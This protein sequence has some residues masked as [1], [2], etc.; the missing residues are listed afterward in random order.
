MSETIIALITFLFFSI[1]SIIY[2]ILK[3]KKCKN[4]FEEIFFHACMT[5][6]QLPH[7]NTRI[8][9]IKKIAQDHIGEPLI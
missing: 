7:D 5:E 8:L 3:L 6:G 4:D 1:F 2:V 9:R